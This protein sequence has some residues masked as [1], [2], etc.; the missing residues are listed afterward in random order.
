MLRYTDISPLHPLLFNF[1]IACPCFHSGIQR[2]WKY[3]PVALS[4]IITQTSVI[5][6][7]VAEECFQPGDDFYNSQL[8]VKTI[9]AVTLGFPGFVFFIRT[10]MAFPKIFLY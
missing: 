8:N 5:V 9:T 2:D 7:H 10:E 4:F 3:T 6:S 1:K